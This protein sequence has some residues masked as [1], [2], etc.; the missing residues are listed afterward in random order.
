MDVIAYAEGTDGDYNTMYGDM[1]RQ[2]RTFSSFTDHPRQ[3]LRSPWGT[4]GVASDA[5]GRYQFLSKTWDDVKKHISVKDFSPENQ[6]RAAVFLIKR[7]KDI[8]AYDNVVNSNQQNRFNAALKSL[9]C[10][11]ASLPPACHPGQHAVLSDELWKVYQAALKKY[12][13]QVEAAS[14]VDKEQSLIDQA[15]ASQH[16]SSLLESASSV[17]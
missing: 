12:R 3:W 4:P 10:V 16:S 8:R 2:R 1:P 9:S 7:A 11:W 17:K 15:S 6:D 13:P 14:L 5:A